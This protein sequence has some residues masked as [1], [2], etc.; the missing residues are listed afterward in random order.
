MLSIFVSLVFAVPASAHSRTIRKRQL[1]H[2]P[3]VGLAMARA[4]TDIRAN[5]ELDEPI[6]VVLTLCY[7]H[8]LVTIVCHVAEIGAHT[9]IYDNSKAIIGNLTYIATARL[10]HNQVIIS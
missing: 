3:V 1:Q 8:S 9:L 5:A 4:K 7:R 6:S 10:V 2:K